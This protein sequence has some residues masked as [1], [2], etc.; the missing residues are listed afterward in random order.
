MTTLSTRTDIRGRACIRMLT[1][2]VNDSCPAIS[3]RWPPRRRRAAAQAALA[4][5]AGRHLTRPS[6]YLRARRATPVRS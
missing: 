5:G 4:A 1:W 6:R 2:T 3:S